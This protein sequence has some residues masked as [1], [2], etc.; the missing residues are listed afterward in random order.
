[1]PLKSPE[2]SFGET[3]RT[4]T[5]TD[6]ANLLD[7]MP[8]WRKT[9]ITR[10]MKIDGLFVAETSNGWVRC[11]D[12]YLAFDSGGYPYPIDRAEFE[13]AYKPATED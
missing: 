2:T 10:A 6:A 12:G 13:R 1:M 11:E 7:E 8:R 5:R 4:F 9:T 3:R